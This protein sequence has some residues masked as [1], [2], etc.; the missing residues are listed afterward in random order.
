MKPVNEKSLIITASTLA[1]VAAVLYFT[2]FLFFE[3]FR[4]GI[5]FYGI[6]LAA[7]TV[8]AN[9]SNSSL[10]DNVKLKKR[11][12]DALVFVPL[13]Y[14][15]LLPI[16]MLLHS[17]AYGGFDFFVNEMLFQYAF[18]EVIALLL[19]ALSLAFIVKEG[20]LRAAGLRSAVLS[21][22]SIALFIRIFWLFFFESR[23]L[24]HFAA[25]VPQYG[26]EYVV[27]VSIPIF[28]AI[29]FLTAH[30]SR[31]GYFLGAAFGAAHVVLVLLI[32][33][34]GQNPGVG[35]FVV[36]LA[37]FVIC[38]FS[39]KGLM[40][41]VQ[42]E[43]EIPGVAFKIMRTVMRIRRNPEKTRH[44][45]EHAGL[46][47]DMKVLDYGCGTGNY[48]IEAAKIVGENGEVVSADI[49]EKMLREVDARTAANGL[50]NVRTQLIGSVDDIKEDNF[51]FILLIDTI[52]LIDDKTD[53]IDL[54]LG[55]LAGG[56]KL[57][58]KFEHM[59][60]ELIE[61]LL[62]GCACSQKIQLFPGKKFWLIN[63]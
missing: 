23:Q 27:L 20:A 2:E 6:F 29:W 38:V 5:V 43:G 57:V 47:K 37:S 59:N 41:N 36:F 46:K 30:G 63:V 18:L 15:F 24:A 56:G 16:G 45:L 21:V 19:L 9:P 49:N 32:L 51:D 54:L 40:E 42:K 55:R 53:T 22:L 3:V 4:S 1:V 44:R 58:I 7:V 10:L 12:L 39:V 52:H 60:S 33:A 61:P 26:V 34:M 28:T 31:A 35:P 8:H 11:C 14:I 13:A 17:N 25:T 50:S 62:D 48:A